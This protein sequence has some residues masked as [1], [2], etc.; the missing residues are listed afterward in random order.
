LPAAG[1]QFSSARRCRKF[2]LSIEFAIRVRMLSKQSLERS[3]S[4]ATVA[5]IMMGSVVLQACASVAPF[6]VALPN[7]Y[8]LRRDRASHIGLIKRGGR[9]VIRGPIAAYAVNGEIVAGCVG[10]WPERP[11]GYPNEIPYPDSPDCRYF[12]LDTDS[13]QLETDLAPKAWRARLAQLG[14]PESLQITAPVLPE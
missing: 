2:F 4:L 6:V 13:G 3:R 12:I 11:S 7:G 8:Y 9:E 14:A 5:L 1:T 10:E